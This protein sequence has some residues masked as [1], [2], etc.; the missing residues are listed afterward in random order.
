MRTLRMSLAGV[1]IA[2]LASV[3][4]GAAMTAQDDGATSEVD[5]RAPASVSGIVRVGTPNQPFDRD[6]WC[7]AGRAVTL[8]Y[9]WTLTVDVDDPRLSGLWTNQY[10]QDVDTRRARTGRGVLSKRRRLLERRVPWLHA[11][12]RAFIGNYYVNFFSGEGGYEGL[13]AMLW[14]ERDRG[15]SGRRRAWCSGSWQPPEWVMPP[16]E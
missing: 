13:S 14:M 5:M 16:A 3:L 4:A 9:G 11:R 15:M 12:P 2:V 8:N 10:H 1:S 7:A 6:T